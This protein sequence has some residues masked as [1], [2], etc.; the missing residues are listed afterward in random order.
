VTGLELFA[1]AFTSGMLAPINPCG[2]ALLPA[3]VTY[4]IGTETG[5]RRSAAARFG[6]GLATG[7]AL[8][9][10]F[11]GTLSLAGLALA[12]GARPVLQAAPWLSL[13]IGFALALIGLVML[14]GRSLPL[15]L[16][17][18]A[19]RSGGTP[20]SA[21]RMI[22]FGAG[23]A[24]ASLTCT[25]GVLLAVV[26]QALAAGSILNVLAVF[27]TYAAGAATLLLL[28][29][30]TAALA[31]TA[32]TRLTRLMTRFGSRVAGAVLILTGI[33]LVT[34]WWPAA[35]RGA[36][37][38]NAIAR[39]VADAGAEVQTWVVTHQSFVILI[40]ALLV[41]GALVGILIARSL[42]AAA[43]DDEA[44]CCVPDEP[45]DARRTG[46]DS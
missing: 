14:A 20:T 43:T 38:D 6:R 23:Y 42:K 40:A 12:L 33:Y 19:R 2:F 44:D 13:G 45:A 18:L 8:T 5:T 35:T 11:A 17:R 21:P 32:L 39:V 30:L 16:P 4:Q 24:I 15:R 36:N 26:T 29:S 7:G 25:F 9:L 37:P 27:A 28:V 41:S 34:Y 1:L 22:A 10:G 3:Y 46:S 31:G